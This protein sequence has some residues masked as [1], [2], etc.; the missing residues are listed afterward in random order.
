[1]IYQWISKKDNEELPQIQSCRAAESTR[2]RKRPLGEN[3]ENF[4]RLGKF[5]KNISPLQEKLYILSNEYQFI[6]ICMD[7]IFYLFSFFSFHQ[8]SEIIIRVCLL[9]PI[10]MSPRFVPDCKKKLAPNFKEASQARQC[11]WGRIGT[12]LQYHL[13]CLC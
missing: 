10:S 13:L 6:H 1:M 11:G 2:V 5:L 3:F 8:T 12:K 7:K 4:P 9:V